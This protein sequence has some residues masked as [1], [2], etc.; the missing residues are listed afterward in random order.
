M[1]NRKRGL[2]AMAATGGSCSRYRTFSADKMRRQHMRNTTGLLADPAVEMPPRLALIERRRAMLAEAAWTAAGRAL[3]PGFDEDSL[4][5]S[6]PGGAARLVRVGLSASESFGLLTES[7]LART[8][9]FATELCAAC[10][11]VAIDPVAVHFE[12]SVATASAACVLVRGVALP[13]AAGD[14]VQIVLSWRGV[15]N[16][17][18]TA[19]SER[20]FVAALRQNRSISRLFDP[21]L[22][23]FAKKR[24][25]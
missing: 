14:T 2:V 25:A 11:L 23:E 15:L 16:R 7:V 22:D 19:R 1:G 24:P 4:V 10:D 12:A 5:V 9:P 21:F 17:K 6:D 18:A 3:V 13:L 20:D 8:D